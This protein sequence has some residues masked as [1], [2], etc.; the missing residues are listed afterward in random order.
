MYLS[1][2]RKY[3]NGHTKVYVNIQNSDIDNSQRVE[4]L[5]ITWWMDKQNLWLY[6]G[7][8]LIHEKVWDTDMCYNIYVSCKHG[9]SKKLVTKDLI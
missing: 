7:I 9:R 3:K 1:M 8:L 4:K 6:S 5:S 2:S